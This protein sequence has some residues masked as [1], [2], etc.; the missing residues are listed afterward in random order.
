MSSKAVNLSIAVWLVLI[1]HRHMRE[2]YGTRSVCVF[3]CHTSCYI[4]GVYYDANKVIL[5][6]GNL[7]SPMRE[8][9]LIKQSEEHGIV[10]YNILS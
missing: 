10:I 6:I 3:C 1:N 2:G 5:G 7:G 9:R 4:P 8:I